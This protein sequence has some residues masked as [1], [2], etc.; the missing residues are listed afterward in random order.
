MSEPTIPAPQITMSFPGG[1]DA[2]G[3]PLAFR[4]FTMASLLTVIAGLANFTIP[5][6]GRMLGF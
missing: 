6:V 2:P 3:Y 1:D 4:V 5:K